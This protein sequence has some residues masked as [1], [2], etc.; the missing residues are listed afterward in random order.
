MELLKGKTVS[1]NIKS[2]VEEKIASLNGD[3]PVLAIIRVGERPGDISY[4][5]SATKKLSGM[6][7]RVISFYLPADIDPDT[8]KNEFSPRRGYQ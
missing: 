8:F 6:G 4:E 2:S 3:V 7:I 1:D 5:N